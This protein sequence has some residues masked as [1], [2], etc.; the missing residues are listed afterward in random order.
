MGCPLTSAHRGFGA[1]EASGA[2]K[3]LTLHTGEEGWDVSVARQGDGTPEARG[4]D[5]FGLSGE[6]S[7]VLRPTAV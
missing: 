4:G 7:M 2:S 6:A 5:P 1:A 3:L